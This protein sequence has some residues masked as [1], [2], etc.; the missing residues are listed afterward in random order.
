MSLFKKNKETNEL[1]K[2]M[3][4]LI[5][6]KSP[7]L[8]EIAQDDA[9]RAAIIRTKNWLSKVD[10]VVYSFCKFCANNPS[11]I[12]TEEDI[13]PS[14]PELGSEYI[15]KHT[16]DCI[17]YGFKVHSLNKEIY[18]KFLTNDGWKDF[19]Q[20]KCDFITLCETYFSLLNISKIDKKL[21]EQRNIY[22]SKQEYLKNYGG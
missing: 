2:F 20:S 4:S 21:Q 17:S 14:Y 3:T 1:D 5:L 16:V 12:W 13:V 6:S 18:V 10:P 19:S 15:M 8:L 11:T 7:L 9:G 22:D